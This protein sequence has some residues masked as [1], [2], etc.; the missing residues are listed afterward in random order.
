MLSFELI[1]NKVVAVDEN[2]IVRAK[3]PYT[4]TKL[5]CK[6]FVCILAGY[7]VFGKQFY[8]PTKTYNGARVPDYKKCGDFLGMSVAKA[9]DKVTRL[10]IEAFVDGK[11]KYIS[12]LATKHHGRDTHIRDAEMIE[13]INKYWGLIETYEKDGLSHL[14]AI[15]LLCRRDSK[16]AK[17]LFG[18]KLWKKLHKNSMTRN[19]LIFKCVRNSDHQDYTNDELVHIVRELNQYPSTILRNPGSKSLSILSRPEYCE[20][21]PQK[22]MKMIAGKHLKDVSEY[23]ISQLAYMVMDCHNMAARLDEPFD[24]KWS[25]RRMAREHDRLVKLQREIKYSPKPFTWLEDMPQVV[26]D[27]EHGIIAKVIN[28]ARAIAEHGN[29]QRHC[30]ANYSDKVRQQLYIVYEV[31]KDDKLYTFGCS[32]RR[33]KVEKPKDVSKYYNKQFFGFANETIEDEHIKN[34]GIELWKK[35]IKNN[36]KRLKEVTNGENQKA[37]D[38]GEREGYAGDLDDIFG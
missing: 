5:P 12:R 21:A 8:Y 35:I 36:E 23:K 25:F 26:E 34:F 11:V 7:G 13:E 24:P 29:T 16:S 6:N 20:N 10:M 14:A 22:F 4:P 30:V 17:E 18:K 32:I 3:F 37:V 27:K 31:T 9:R 19:D 38:G 1:Q 15:G 2:D 33:P 28:N